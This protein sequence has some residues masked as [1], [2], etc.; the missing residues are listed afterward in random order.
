LPLKK[1]II[2]TNGLDPRHRRRLETD[3]DSLGFTTVHTKARS[4]LVSQAKQKR[5]CLYILETRSLNPDGEFSCM[6]K[7]REHDRLAPIIFVT[8]HSSEERVLKALRAGVS[9]YFKEPYIYDDLLQSAVTRLA[10]TAC[11]AEASTANTQQ[12]PLLIGRSNKIRT[13]RAYIQKVSVSDTTVLITGET[14]TGKELAAHMIHESS[15]RHKKPMV[16]VNCAALPDNLVESELFGFE[17]GAF[18]GAVTASR[19]RFQQAHEGTIFLDEIGDMTPFAQAKI[20]RVIEDKQISPLGGSRP[21]PLNFRLITATSRDPESLLEDGTF[22]DDLFYR[23]NIGRIHMPPLRENREDIPEL[24]EF[25]IEKFNQKFKRNIQGLKADVLKLL[26]RYDWPGNVRELMNI[27]EGAFINLP[28]KEIAY[29]DLP[30]H[31]KQKLMECQTSPSDERKR[32][33]S[34]LL[35]TKWNKSNAAKKLD[36]SRMTLYRKMAKLKIVEKRSSR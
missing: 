10:P 2:L 27:L 25:G 23:L 22:R 4:E 35:E 36:W 31:L 33:I 20:L 24:I 18:T 7:I 21:I 9:D 6:R 19:G 1:S 32:I 17:R 16:C 34:A 28:K 13:T 29:A 12:K 3:F 5:V 30:M 11:K 15:S 8:K 14:G 26:L